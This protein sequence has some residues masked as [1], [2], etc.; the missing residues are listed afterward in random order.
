ML[1]S[2]GRKYYDR[3]RAEGKTHN[4]AMRCLKRRIADHIW[5]LMLADERL[6]DC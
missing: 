1:D 4:E 6:H 5:R 2:I 3:K